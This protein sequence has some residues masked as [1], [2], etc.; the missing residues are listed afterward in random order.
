MADDQSRTEGARSFTPVAPEERI[1][2]LD[3]L[4][5]FALLGIIVMNMPS[6]NTAAGSGALDERLFPSYYDRAAE[7]V[8]SVIFAGKANSIFS[9]LFGLG[10][11]IQMQRAEASGQPITPLYLRRVAV[12]FLVGAAHGI[13]LWSGDVLHTYAVLGLG[14]L[15]LRRVSDRWVF[16]L[17]AFALVAPEI[18]GVIALALNEPPIHPREFWVALAHEHQRIFSV[19]TYVEQ[20]QARLFS[21]G[22]WYGAIRSGWGAIWGYVSFTV[23]IL[24]GFYAGRKRLLEDLQGNAARIRKVM[25]VCLGLGLAA[26]AGFSLL[27]ATSPTPPPVGP[28]FRGFIT[29][30]L[31]NLNRPLLCIAYIAAIALL[32]Q[33]DRWKRVLMVL[34]EPGRMPL[35]NYL[36]QSSIATTIFYSYGFGLFGKVGPLLGLGISIAIFVFQ[37]FFSRFWLARFRFGPLEWLWRAAT[38]G[39]LPAMARGDRARDTEPG[40]A[41]A[42]AA[43]ATA[44]ERGR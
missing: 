14:L 7:F 26:S 2:V 1:P 29:G 23:T 3:V 12:L 39:K 9:F 40:A 28:T 20:I 33:R 24:L 13:L 44:D 16:G 42:I 41:G 8:S 43:Q 30:L 15:A 21:Y 11:T 27:V 18:R 36:M 25:W 31:Y 19:G 34:A 10:L 4:R 32:I 38:Y 22:L 37:I 5:G 17:I 35:T 6:F